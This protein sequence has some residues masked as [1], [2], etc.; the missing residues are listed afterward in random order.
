[1]STG[2]SKSQYASELRPGTVVSTVLLCTDVRARQTKSGSWFADVRLADRTGEISMKLWNYNQQ[3]LSSLA[4]GVFVR[5]RNL[6]VTEYNG[7]LQLSVDSQ[8]YGGAFAICD[9]EECDLSDFVP[10]TSRDVNGMASELLETIAS[11]RQQPV[12]CL[13]DSFFGD[14]E[15]M[16]R[17]REWPA[18]VKHHHAYSGGLLEHTLC[19]LR[20]CRCAAGQYEFVN[21]DMLAAGALLHDVGKMRSYDY[22]RSR[23]AASMSPAG[24]MTDHIVLGVE[25]VSKRIAELVTSCPRKQSCASGCWTQQM[26]LEITHMIVSHHGTLEWGSPVQP[27]TIEACI[28]HHADNMDAQVNKFERT[29][30]DSIAAGGGQYRYSEHVGKMVWVPASQTEEQ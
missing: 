6:T 9:P 29:I 28:L 10:S 15:F 19:V 2:V 30:R 16:G 27:A 21:W 14:V 1:M 13:L 8:Q 20:V 24:V 12:K 5:L 4:P 25:M 3:A 22:E 23:G 18:A 7:N 11:V 17:F 26:A